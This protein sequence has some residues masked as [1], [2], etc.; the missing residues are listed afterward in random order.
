MPTISNLPAAAPPAPEDALPLEQNGTTARV[1]VGDLLAGTQ[2]A[3]TLAAGALLGRASPGPGGPEAVA[4]GSGLQLSG[5]VL[6]VTAVLAGSPNLHSGTAAPPVFLGAEGDTYLDTLTGDLYGRAQGVWAKSGNLMGPPGSPGPQGPGGPPGPLPS[7]PSASLLGG[8]GGALQP[9]ALTDGLS[10]TGGALGV[11]TGGLDVSGSAVSVAGGISRTL[12]N[13]LSDAPTLRQF[14]AVGDGKSDDTQAVQAALEAGGTPLAPSGSYATTLDF[15]PSGNFSGRLQ[16]MGQVV[17]GDG[18]RHAPHVARLS[19]APSAFGDPGDIHSAFNGDLSHVHLAIEHRID[20]AATLGQPASGY[21]QHPETSAVFLQARSTS[22]WNQLTGDQG[23]RTG[24]ALVT[25]GIEQAGQGD[26]IVF[27][28]SAGVYSTRAGATHYLASPAGVIFDGEL[29]AF[30]PGGYLEE[31]EFGFVD[32]GYDIAV[33]GRVWNFARTNNAGAL[34]CQWVGDRFQSNG[35]VGIDAAFFLSGLINRAIDTTRM[36]PDAQGAWAV[37]AGG[38]K[39]ALNGS[40]ADGRLSAAATKAGT[41]W[42]CYD[43]A[44]GVVEI[45]HNGAPVA[46]L[47]NP[48]GAVNGWALGG[49]VSGGAV[50]LTPQGADPAIFAMLRDKGG[51]GV[52]IESNDVLV[53]KCTGNVGDSSYLGLSSAAAGAPVTIQAFGTNAGLALV[54]SGTGKVTAPTVVSSDSSTAVATTA[55]VKA[56]GYTT[57]AT[58]NLGVRAGRWYGPAASVGSAGPATGRLY[59]LPFFLPVPATPKALAIGVAASSASAASFRLGIYADNGGGLPGALLYD[60]GTL[61]IAAGAAGAQQGPAI[62]GLSLA[63]GWYW[64]ASIFSG[65]A[66]PSVYT[67]ALSPLALTQSLL[68]G[69]SA[70]GPMN[71]GNATTGLGMTLAFGALPASFANPPLT[72]DSIQTP[73]VSIGF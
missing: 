16:G 12:A 31:E 54:P 40:N 37:V 8:G 63:P 61:T 10:L 57:V 49:A 22:G 30:A 35:S 13:H 25:A 56:Q 53:A 41:E 32:N 1:T 14:G 24:T 5:G 64:L 21:M 19:Q 15:G 3:L 48:S 47:A 60:S 45:A 6:S 72:N 20:G 23:G 69:S 36:T 59:A 7:V 51:A 27:N 46:S 50:T 65:S 38:Q 67:A 71:N 43:P 29:Q 18:N 58:P 33:N 42:L 55:W 9:V 28:L 68:G 73:Y 39:L 2:S 4:L 17:G 26:A 52:V 62:A 34:G 70:L 66:L 11:A 44:T